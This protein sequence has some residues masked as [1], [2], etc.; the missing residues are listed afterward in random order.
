MSNMK[1]DELSPRE[2]RKRF[3]NFVINNLRE[4]NLAAGLINEEITFRDILI[5]ATKIQNE[6][7]LNSTN[8]VYK[9]SQVLA[10]NNK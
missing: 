4:I 1:I 5:I 9:L 10:V 2:K 6:E 8:I 7:T 3:R